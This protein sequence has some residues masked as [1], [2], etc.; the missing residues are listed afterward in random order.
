MT[1]IKVIEENESQGELK[2]VYEEIQKSR[3]KVANILKSHSLNPGAL[4]AHLDLYLILMFG[5]S[6]L[7][8]EEREMLAVCVS[9]ANNCNY[10]RTHH[11]DALKVYWKNA[12]KIEAFKRDWRKVLDGP[13]NRAML[14]YAEK[15][16]KSPDVITRDDV[17]SLREYFTDREILDITL[18]TAYFNFVNRIALGLGV[19]VTEEELE[20]YRY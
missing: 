19:E 7:N 16:T 13:R 14:E 6:P 9:S 10:C 11:G 17:E 2:K 1:W 18:I 15:L 8:S 3:G 20:G 5:D 4:K 12:D